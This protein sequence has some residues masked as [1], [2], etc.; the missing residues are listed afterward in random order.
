MSEPLSRE[1]NELSV[2]TQ[3]PKLTFW[4]YSDR[5]QWNFRYSGLGVQTEPNSME[6][7]FGHSIRV[8]SLYLRVQ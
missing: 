4:P 5:P 1:S 7:K 3:T 2:R 6:K 8:S